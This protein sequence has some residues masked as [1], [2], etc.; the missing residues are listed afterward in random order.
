MREFDRVPVGEAD[1]AVREQVHNPIDVVE[2]ALEKGA[3]S[4]MM[5]VASR[6]ALMDL[7]DDVATKVQ[8]VFYL[9][10]ADALRKAVH[11]G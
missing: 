8:V 11:E 9:D 2:L 6:R 5:P 1:A 4:V 7:S 10:A 3:T